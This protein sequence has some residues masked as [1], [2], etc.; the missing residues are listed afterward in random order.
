[1]VSPPGATHFANSGKVGKAPL[2][3]DGGENIRLRLGV[4]SR[5][6]PRPPFTGAHER[7]SGSRIRRGWKFDLDLRRR[8]LPLRS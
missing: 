7:E 4:F 1:M 8:P 6:P 2:G 3:V 5:L